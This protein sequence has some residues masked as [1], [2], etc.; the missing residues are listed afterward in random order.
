MARYSLAPYTIR[1]KDKKSDK[2]VHIDNISGGE[3][4]LYVMNNYLS[5]RKNS[6][7]HQQSQKKILRIRHF[8]LQNRIFSGIIE[9]GEYGY[10]TEL[11]DANS[12]KTTYKRHINEAEMLPFYLLMYLPQNAD[13][14]ILIL[15]RF[16]QYGIRTNF[17][18]DIN[19]YVKTRFSSLELQINPLVTSQL[20]NEYLRH[21]R[22]LKLRFIR[23]SFP[24]DIANAYDTQDHKEEEGYTELVISAKRRGR[25][26]I[27][28]RILEVI[29]GKRQLNELIEI[30]D[31]KY[32]K[33]KIEIDINGNKRTIDLSDINKIRPYIDITQNIK[34]GDNGHP[35][36]NS[37]DAISRELLRDLINQ[38]A[39]D[40]NVR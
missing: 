15:Q 8:T 10:E 2:Y 6:V 1:I 26:P 14:G 33:V 13:E 35:L 23:F 16:K 27:I 12:E 21:G 40:N 24:S 38:I 37:I 20:I 39:R 34:L 4:F 17:E 32:E 22:V 3:D 31:F 5:N 11:F 19:E 29:N 9:T 36:F 28:G 30:K 25:I 18:R 7:G